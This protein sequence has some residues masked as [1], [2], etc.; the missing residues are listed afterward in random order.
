M[1][2][3]IRPFQTVSVRPEGHARPRGAHPRRRRCNGRKQGGG[4]LHQGHAGSKFLPDSRLQ[5]HE[6]HRRRHRSCGRVQ[7]LL[8]DAE[9]R[10]GCEED[11]HADHRRLYR[12]HRIIRGL[13]AFLHVR[14]WKRTRI[15]RT[16][17]RVQ[18]TPE[19]VGIHG[20]PRPL[21]H[22]G[23]GG[24]R[25]VLRGIH[26]LLHRPWETCRVHRHAGDGRRRAGHHLR[27]AAR[28]TAQQET[29]EG[30]LH[31]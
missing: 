16:V 13:A 10:P 3:C 18:G 14:P 17:S 15:V 24:H 21:P 28:R 2:T 30:H 7:C 12:V 22:T 27:Q 1:P 19:A 4:G 20:H 11:H 31:L 9:R 5:P 6:G 8:H 29:G 26:R 25:R 23:G